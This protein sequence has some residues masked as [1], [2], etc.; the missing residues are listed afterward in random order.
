MLYLL[1]SSQKSGTSLGFSNR[2]DLI[3]RTCYKRAKKPKKTQGGNLKRNKADPATIP[4]GGGT[5]GDAT[6]FQG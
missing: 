3:Q 2:V 4:K 6:R 1:E 5:T